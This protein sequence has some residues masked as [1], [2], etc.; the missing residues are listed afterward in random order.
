MAGA[1]IRGIAVVVPV[2]NE[3]ALLE[4]CLHGIHRACAWLEER[5]ATP[6]RTAVVLALDSCVD[7]SE[8]IA[9]RSGVQVIQLGLRN[10]GLARAAGVRAALELLSDIDPEEIWLASTDADSFVPPDWLLAQQQLADSGWDVA[11]G[12][13][14]PD[15]ADLPV[16]LH[17]TPFASA[18]SSGEPVYGAN[19]GV[20]I[21][22]YLT[23]GGFT[24]AR[25]HEDQRL[26]GALRRTG[27][28]VTASDST[29]VLTSG[30][31]LGRTPGG[32]AGFL[33]QALSAATA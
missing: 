22:A 6:V 9:A 1:L 5:S 21:S 28:R 3:E 32:Y 14:Q 12:R 17:R 25:E 20:R 19:L 13:V 31:V 15:L 27:A 2:W 18:A 8:A 26:V 24:A 11:L 4:R 10:V 7:G 16:E 33:R 30:R 23:A 29:P